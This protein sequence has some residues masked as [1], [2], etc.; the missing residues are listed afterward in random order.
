MTTPVYAVTGASGRLGRLAV[1]QL[2]ARGV[3]PSDIVA[4]V[5]TPAKA[6]SLAASG[7]HVRQADYSRPATLR[8]VLSGVNRL[9]PA[10]ANP[11]G[12][13]RAGAGGLV[14]PPVRPHARS[15]P[16]PESGISA[17]QHGCAARDL[18]PE[19]AD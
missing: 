6:I 17:G 16:R 1:E 9:L 18:N 13:A 7:V 19:P 8:A 2:T 4:L 12:A 11:E 3:P 14:M 5:R 10:Q 15:T